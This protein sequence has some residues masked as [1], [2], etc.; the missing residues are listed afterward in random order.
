VLEHVPEPGAL[1]LAHAAEKA[2]G[3]AV[4][5][6]VLGKARERL[7]QRIDEGAT[8]TPGRPGLQRLQVELQADDRE[9]RVQR[10]TNIDRT[11]ENAHGCC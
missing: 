8:Q 9:M 2:A 5:A 4:R 11:I 3:L 7:T 1:A 10:G 6:A